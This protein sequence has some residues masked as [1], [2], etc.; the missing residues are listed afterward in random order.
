ML[1]TQ[2]VRDTGSTNE[3]YFI[4]TAAR[5]SVED[6]ESNT[7]NKAVIDDIFIVAMC[8][9][10]KYVVFVFDCCDF[11]LRF[12]IGTVAKAGGSKK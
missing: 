3:T 11:A 2:T 8:I 5:A 6:H 1:L 12:G 4:S 9:N 7:I 10:R